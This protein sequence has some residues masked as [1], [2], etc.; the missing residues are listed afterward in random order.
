MEKTRVGILFGGVSGEHEVSLMSAHSILSAISKDRYD[1]LQIGIDHTGQWLSGVNTLEV[2]GN[3]HHDGLERVF[4]FPYPDQGKLYRLNG[5]GF[6]LFRQLDVI[7]PL[8]HGSFGEDGNLQGYLELMN[9]P[10]VGANVASSAVCMEK[11]LFKDIMR[12]NHIP[13]AE[14]LLASRREVEGSPDRITQQVENRFQYPVFVK[15]SNLG[16][17][18]GVSRCCS[19]D[20]LLTG[21]QDAA[22]YSQQIAIEQGV[23]AWEIEVS[24]LGNGKEVMV[25]APGQVCYQD[26]FY[27]YQAKYFDEKTVLVIPAPIPPHTAE[28][29]RRVAGKVYQLVGCDGMA[30]IDFLVEKSS[31]TVYVNEINTIPGFTHASMYPRLWEYSG[32]A[33]EKLIDSLIDLAFERHRERQRTSYQ[34]IPV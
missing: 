16:S 25:S 3:G 11:G 34:Y 23:D 15:P 13:V 29:I 33:Y 7:F 4:M 17:S 31:Q 19:Q 26:T 24:A 14:M 12:A 28:E 27:S 5:K 21:M 2:M 30:R 20:E 9:I 32:I 18:V 1:V 22:R 10:Y 6:A 8:L